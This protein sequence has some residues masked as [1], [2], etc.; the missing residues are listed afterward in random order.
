MPDD[1]LDWRTPC[2]AFSV[3]D[4][5][6]HL[7]GMALAF[8]AAAAKTPLEGAASGDA[9]RLRPDWRTRIP[10]D[11]LT[12]AEAWRDPDAWTGMTGAGGVELP[13]EVAG[14][15]ALDELVIHGWDLAKATA[16]RRAMTAQVWS[17]CTRWSSS[18]ER[19]VS[20]ASSA[21][22]SRCP[23]MPRCSIGSS[24]WPD[25]T[26]AGAGPPSAVNP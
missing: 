18:S 24:A 10:R 1:A 2:E 20:R 13:G 14:A 16:S 15:V 26:P 23:R 11:L 25:E 17:P 5:L 7:G 3:G 19:R 6:D 12:L 21:P 8:T 9:A 22:R 4:L